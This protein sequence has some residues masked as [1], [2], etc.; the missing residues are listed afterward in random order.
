[1]P[2]TLQRLDTALIPATRKLTALGDALYNSRGEGFNPTQQ[3]DIGI[4]Y[5]AAWDFQSALVAQMDTLCALDA[6]RLQKL[7][8]DLKNRL[9]LV[10]GYASLLKREAS[11]NI[12]SAQ[13]VILQGMLATGETIMRQLDELR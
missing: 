2:S 7:R 5:N 4:I 11:S 9:N 3:E 6:L 13:Q 8:H 12:S 10:I 1:M